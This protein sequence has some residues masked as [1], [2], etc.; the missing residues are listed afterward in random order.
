MENSA[1]S[2]SSTFALSLIL[3]SGNA[4][5]EK[6]ADAAALQSLLLKDP[7]LLI[8]EKQIPR[9]PG[10]DVISFLTS[11]IHDGH[12]DGLR[13]SLSIPPVLYSFCTF[14]GSKG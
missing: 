8:K 5:E 7:N 1:T 10:F 4:K 11:R 14:S 3:V 2:L 6:E 13:R 12:L 9:Y